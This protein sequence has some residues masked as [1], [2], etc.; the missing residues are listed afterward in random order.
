MASGALWRAAPLSSSRDLVHD[1]LEAARMG[2]AQ[3]H[4]DPRFWGLVA[5]LF[6]LLLASLVN[7]VSKINLFMGLSGG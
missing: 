3:M 1:D 2:D 6:V 5:L 7:I 4:N